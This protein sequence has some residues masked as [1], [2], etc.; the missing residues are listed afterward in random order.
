V[1]ELEKLVAEKEISKSEKIRAKA[2]ILGT[3]IFNSQ[4]PLSLEEF[5]REISS[6]TSWMESLSQDIE[7]IKEDPHHILNETILGSLV[8]TIEI[9]NFLSVILH[10]TASAPGSKKGKKNKDAASQDSGSASASTTG[11][12][13]QIRDNLSKAATLI[14]KALI[15]ALA[16]VEQILHHPEQVLNLFVSQNAGHPAI[17]FVSLEVHKAQLQ[18]QGTAILNS[19]LDSLNHISVE[20]SKKKKLLSSNQ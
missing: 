16:A 19:I 2:V 13:Q 1:A 3:K 8:H 4:T 11:F 20:L 12:V 7:K 6:I 9:L 10:H 14:E 17:N 5:E 15:V 18:E